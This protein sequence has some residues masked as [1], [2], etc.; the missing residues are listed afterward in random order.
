MDKYVLTLLNEILDA[1]DI[2]RFE[3]VNDKVEKE[4]AEGKFE[5][6][7]DAIL[8]KIAL[9]SRGNNMINSI[10]NGENTISIIISDDSADV[11]EVKLKEMKENE[12]DEIKQG[13]VYNLQSIKKPNKKE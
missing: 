8:L 2:L 6:E 7:L 3:K 13:K 1:N 9:L 10:M 12:L 11:E 5:N 4:I